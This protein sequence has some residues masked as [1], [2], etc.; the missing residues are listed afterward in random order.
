MHYGLVQLTK[1]PAIC[2]MVVIISIG[3]MPIIGNIDLLPHV[4]ISN[5]YIKVV[6]LTTLLQHRP[7]HCQPLANY[8]TL[9]FSYTASNKH[10][11]IYLFGVSL[12][13]PHIYV[14][15]EER[16]C[17]CIYIHTREQKNSTKMIK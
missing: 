13:E 8:I 11:F 15:G 9:I 3:P 16:V 7:P 6:P 5:V 1:F 17:L 14:C 12:S 4:L 2:H 10:L